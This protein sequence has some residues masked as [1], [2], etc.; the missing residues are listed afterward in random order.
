MRVGQWFRAGAVALALVCGL[1]PMQSARANT[2]DVAFWPPEV[3]P[4]DLCSPDASLDTEPG[5]GGQADPLAQEGTLTDALRLQ[6]LRQ[7]INRLQTSEP[8]RWFDFIL[9]LIGWEAELDPAFAGNDELLARIGLY[10]DAGK[11]ELLQ[12]EGLIERLRQTVA[13]M[14]NAQKMALAQYYL[15]GIGVAQDAEFAR[16]LI[17]DAA[18]GGNVSALLSIVRMNL[19]GNPVPGWDAPMDLTVTL[20]FGGMLG[21]MDPGVCDHA[22]RIAREYLGGDV[23]THNP[24]IAYAWYKFAADLGSAR[25]AWRVVEFHLEADAARKD[26]DEMLHYLQLAVKRGLTLKQGQ[27]AALSESGDVDEAT[28][29]Q[30]LGYNLSAD[31]GRGRPSLASY[32]RLSVNLLSDLPTK[33][34]PYTQYLKELTRFETTPGWVFTEL[35]AEVEERKG[36]WA[37]EAEALAFL[38]QAALRHDSEGIAMLGQRL[39]HSRADPVQLNRSINLLTQAV[40]QFGSAPAMHD[41]DTLYRCQAPDAPLLTEADHW[42]RAYRATMDE[43]VEANPNDLLVLDPYKEPEVFGQLQSQ[44]IEGRPQSLANFLERLQLDPRATDDARQMWALRASL[45][46]KALEDFAKLEVALAT[47]PAER[48]LAIELFRR[49]TLNNGVTTALDLSIALTEDF[50]RNPVVAADVIGLLTHAGNRGEGASIRLKSRLLAKSVPAQKIYDEFAV[51]IEERGDFLA[52]MFAMPFVS[53]DK[54]Q[55]YIE[56]AVSQMNCGTKDADELG[57]AMAILQS[58][59]MSTHW[60]TVGLNV[61]FYNVLAKLAIADRQMTAFNE[62]SPPSELDVFARNLAEGDSSALRSL[63]SLTIDPDLKTYDPTA[64]AGH[65]QALMRQNSTGN[66]G[67]LL[68]RYKKASVDVRRLIASQVD[69][70][71]LLAKAAQKGD[72]AAKLDYALIL[73]DTA[74]SLVDLQS[75]TRWLTEAAEAGN[76]VA[77]VALGQSLASGIG[78]PQDRVKALEWLD[79]AAAAGDAG[80]KDLARLLRIGATP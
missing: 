7:D 22:E 14:T 71:S 47:N 78:L 33:E 27:V 64:A 38:E 41:L 58:P 12:S 46:P 34:S 13:V 72:A 21:K 62:G 37:G 57:D 42:A 3:E 49:I 35:A 5:T 39:V 17:R 63:V 30:M 56:R 10:I 24:E 66:E 74:T 69:I 16:D 52:L 36:R 9:T 80:G 54:A 76:V 18:Y 73:R 77:M 55:D 70:G 25:A 48:D 11:L 6:F 45:S 31:T 50:G 60:R 79:R 15:N 32:F 75:S 40:E 20:A 67:W 23:V 51:A 2:I 68:G 8:A 53:S 61:E 59:E 26:N 1:Q 44:A 28:L 29:R 65:L 4:Q 19:Q 43:T